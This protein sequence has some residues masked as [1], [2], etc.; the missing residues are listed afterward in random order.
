MSNVVEFGVVDQV[1]VRSTATDSFGADND[2]DV[3]MA[4]SS[5]QARVAMFKT[6][7]RHGKNPRTSVSDTSGP[8]R[9]ALPNCC[10]IAHEILTPCYYHRDSQ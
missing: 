4:I 8:H 5:K 1:I 7:S 10:V 3:E 6:D 2:G 9:M